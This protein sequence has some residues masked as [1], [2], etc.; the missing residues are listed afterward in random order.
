MQTLSVL[1][2]LQRDKVELFSHF[3]INAA[4]SLYPFDKGFE[5]KFNATDKDIFIK[6]ICLCLSLD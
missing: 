3:D 1:H 5:N 4:L 6:S 2:I